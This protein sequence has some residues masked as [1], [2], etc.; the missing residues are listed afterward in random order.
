MDTARAAYNTQRVYALI[1]FAVCG[2][3]LA[4][5]LATAATYAYKHTHIHIRIY[6]GI[7]NQIAVGHTYTYE[8]KHYRIDA[9]L[10]SVI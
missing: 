1:W 6:S 4:S 2:D 9:P 7:P 10:H 8:R 5:V 3:V